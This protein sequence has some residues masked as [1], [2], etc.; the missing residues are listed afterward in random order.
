MISSG[1]LELYATGLASE[2]E[3]E[4]VMQWVND[5]PEV[6]AELLLIEDGLQQYAQLNDLQPDPTLK[7]RIFSR[8]NEQQE[9]AKVVPLVAASTQGSAA[10]VPAWWKMVAAASVFLLAG[11]AVLNYVLYNKNESAHFQLSQ[12]QAAKSSLEVKNDMMENDLQIIQS[13]YSQPVAL[14][15]LPVLPDAAAKVFWMKNTGEVYVDPSNL[16]QAPQGKQYELWAIVDG[17]PVNAGIILNTK[18]GDRYLIQKMKS[19]GSAQ[20]FAVS[21]EPASKAPAQSPTEVVSMGKM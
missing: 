2:Q 3:A 5:Y 17:K 1:L 8:I 15:G 13:K 12:A 4:L 7:A 10:V 19:F 21:L 16:P 11:S 9:L 6:A 20:A 18:K 14:N